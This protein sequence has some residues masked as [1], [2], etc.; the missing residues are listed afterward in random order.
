[1]HEIGINRIRN[2][3]AR[4][5]CLC[6]RHFFYIFSPCYLILNFQ[7]AIV[8]YY[9]TLCYAKCVR[10]VNLWTRLQPR[11]LKQNDDQKK[12][13]HKNKHDIVSRDRVNYYRWS[14][15]WVIGEWIFHCRNLSAN[16]ADLFLT[17]NWMA[18]DRFWWC[19]SSK[20]KL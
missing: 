12:K 10:D 13:K 16:L 5:I 3:R 15:L 14:S 11:W 7:I 6:N 17:T 8:N 1:M 20:K 9:F 19:D 18:V 2:E 4:I